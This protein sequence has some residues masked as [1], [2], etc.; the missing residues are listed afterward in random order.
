MKF[1]VFTAIAFA[2]FLTAYDVGFHR[3]ALI[4]G[5]WLIIRVNG[6][7]GVFDPDVR[8]IVGTWPL[9]SDHCHIRDF[10]LS[11]VWL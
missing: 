1:A 6:E 9:K 11:R 5:D 7:C 10:I 3:S 4:H 8:K 2:C